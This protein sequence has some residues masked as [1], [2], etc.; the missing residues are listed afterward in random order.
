MEIVDCGTVFRGQSGTDTASACFPSICRLSGGTL[1]VSWRTGSSKDSADGTIRLSATYDDG[2]TWSEPTVPFDRR[3]KVS[4]GTF[5]FRGVPGELHYMG[6]TVLNDQILAAIMWLD[7]TDPARPMFNDDTEGLV[8][9]H[10]LLARSRNAGLSWSDPVLLD[11]GEYEGRATVCAPFLILPDGRLTFQFETNKPYDSREVW[12]Q[13]ACLRFSD[14]HGNSWRDS[15]IVAHDSLCRVRFWDQHHAI[16]PDGTQVAT[17]WTYD[18]HLKRDMSFHLARSVDGGRTWSI[19]VDTGYQ[20]QVPY[21]VFLGNGR[22]VVFVVDRFDSPSIRVLVSED[23]GEMFRLIDTPVYRH[24]GARDNSQFDHRLSDQQRWT[25]GRIEA[26]P[27]GSSEVFAVFYSGDVS[28][29]E[30]SW[31]KLN[32]V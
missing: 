17:F 21:P 18:S 11:A 29:T 24:A 26:V 19:P 5:R 2:H 7:R 31:V 14:D 3:T 6:L 13:R 4:P 23:D 16:S 12:D 1:L 28:S 9:S 10:T 8:E 15:T 27:V 20:Y 30:I 32:F 22:L 25:F